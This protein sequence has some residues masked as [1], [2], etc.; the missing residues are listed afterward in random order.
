[1]ARSAP[2]QAAWLGQGVCSVWPGCDRL[3][4]DL[5]GQ[6]AP[7]RSD[8]GGINSQLP[9]GVAKRLTKCLKTA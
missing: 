8:E 7:P 9:R 5:A 1:M 3:Q 2:D 6:P 4:P